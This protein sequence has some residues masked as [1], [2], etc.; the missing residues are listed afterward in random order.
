[1]S[2]VRHRV[3]QRWRRCWTG[4][5]NPFGISQR[6]KNL[7]AMSK[8]ETFIGRKQLYRPNTTEC[9]SRGSSIC[10]SAGRT[11]ISGLWT[12]RTI[13]RVPPVR[14]EHKCRFMRGCCARCRLGASLRPRTWSYG[15]S[16]WGCRGCSSTS[17]IKVRS[18]SWKISCIEAR[19]NYERFAE[20]VPIGQ[21]I[22]RTMTTRKIQIR[23]DFVRTKPYAGS[24][25]RG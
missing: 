11:D 17:S 21:R 20:T 18:M 15:K 10:C 12:G 23:A 8:D 24:L 25:T 2:L 22:L 13:Q 5:K 7:Y 9:E 6:W 19:K 16:I 1:M 3:Q 14:Q 4:W